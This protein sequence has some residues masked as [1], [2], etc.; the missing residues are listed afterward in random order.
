MS[1]KIIAVKINDGD[2]IEA[3]ALAMENQIP[4]NEE[5]FERVSNGMTF[6]EAVKDIIKTVGKEPMKTKIKV[7]KLNKILITAHE[8]GYNILDVI[9]VINEEEYPLAYFMEAGIKPQP[10]V[11]FKFSSLKEFC[12]QCRASGVHL[13]NSNKENSLASTSIRCAYDAALESMQFGSSKDEA[14]LLEEVNQEL[15]KYF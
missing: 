7:N 1:N 9:K 13:M 6:L 14:N 5:V 8:K 15:A 2:L 11:K 3:G 12:E 4:L 10:F